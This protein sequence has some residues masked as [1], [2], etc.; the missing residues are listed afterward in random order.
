MNL[1]QRLYHGIYIR[2]RKW[3][4]KFISQG[5]YTGVK[6]SIGQPV[7]FSGP[8]TIHF[9]GLCFFGVFTSPGFYST[10]GYIE[11]RGK[12]SKIICGDST[13]FNNNCQI[14]AGEG[15]IRVGNQCRIGLNCSI[16]NSDF[17]NI[18]PATRDTPPFPSGDI[19][20]GNNIYI[21]N[22]VTILKGV[23][24]GDNVT[25]GIGSVVTRDIPANC[26]AAGI[27]ARVIKQI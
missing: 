21:G 24:I 5:K 7:L 1:L 11:A 10:Y 15:M 27:P 22:N 26:I 14:I 25:I 2:F 18:D 19:T 6:P 4:Y 23:T 3:H 17:H 9:E 12:T 16:L 13:I 20:I 8:G